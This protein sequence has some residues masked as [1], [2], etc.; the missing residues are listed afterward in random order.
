[1]NLVRFLITK[2]EQLGFSFAP[3]KPV[4][5]PGS[6][7]G[8]YR[9]TDEGDVRYDHPTPAAPTV[10]QHGPEPSSTYQRA[11][12]AHRDVS[13][14][15]ETVRRLYHARLASDEQMVQAVKDLKEAG[16][17]LDEAER[18]EAAS[19]LT[20]HKVK[21]GRPVRLRDP[22]RFAARFNSPEHGGIVG[23]GGAILPRE[24]LEQPGVISDTSKD[25][26]RVMIHWPEAGDGNLGAW[27]DVDML[28]VEPK[29]APAQPPPGRGMCGRCHGQGQIHWADGSKDVCGQ[30]NGSGTVAEKPATA[31]ATAPKPEPQPKPDPPAAPAPASK[32]P[33]VEGSDLYQ[34]AVAAFS[35]T[36]FTPEKRAEAAIREY[37]E[38]LTADYALLSKLAKTDEKKATLA[39]EWPRY[40]AGYHAK[41][42]AWLHSRS[43][44]MS[45][46][47]AGPSN[48]PVRR[49]EKQL[50]RERNR[51]DD[52]TD[53]RQRA[54][55]AIRKKLTPELQPIMAG[56]SDATTRL[57]EE[58]AKLEKTRDTYKAINAAIRKHK[59]A[60]PEA[61]VKAI[62]EVAGFKS[63]DTARKLLEPDFAGRVGIADYQLTNLGANIRRLQ[64]RL[65]SVSEAKATPGETVEGQHATIEDDPPGNR[66]RLTFPGKP[67][68]EVRSRLKHG[69]FRWAPTLGVWQAYRNTNSLA[70]ARE[71]AGVI[72]KA[73][74]LVLRP[75]TRG[76]HYRVT[77]EGA[78]R[79]D[80]P[81][82]YLGIQ[83]GVEDEARIKRWEAAQADEAAEARGQ[84]L[85]RLEGRDREA[86]YAEHLAASGERDPRLQAMDERLAAAGGSAEVHHA[87]ETCRQCGYD[88][89]TK[90]SGSCAFCGA[91]AR[92]RGR[93]V[94]ALLLKGR[95]QQ[96]KRRL[97]ADPKDPDG[98]HELGKTRRGKPVYLSGA[99]AGG[100]N[101]EDHLDAATFHARAHEHH[102]RQAGVHR[103][104]RD[105]DD[106][107]QRA[108]T[109]HEEHERHARLA[110]HHLD[111]VREHLT[112][113]GR[114]GAAMLDATDG[115]PRLGEVVPFTDQDRAEA[116]AALAKR[117]HHDHPGG[118]TDHDRATYG[119]FTEGK[120]ATARD[121]T[122]SAQSR[123]RGPRPR[124]TRRAAG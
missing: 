119:R 41:Y 48:F 60:G 93:I 81:A 99:E 124:P 58:I 121:T 108:E 61:Q 22:A 116:K 72:Q 25:K 15:H 69:G 18:A 55:A 32:P 47:I 77:G 11:L 109:H 104:A 74:R 79:Y 9:I 62:M 26:R 95:V 42:A 114:G 65:T 68:A 94:K 30:C 90:R 46:M 87:Q 17:R 50:A 40:V 1:M 12:D 71:V 34:A 70:L 91:S 16:A 31:P 45:P 10:V 8:H 103:T 28:M 97:F 14:R 73:R 19:T 101:D 37:E 53:Y 67:S 39:A 27:V 112:A 43:G 38:T 36:S 83:R 57:R 35:G 49:H 52:A 54:L 115:A 20:V 75:G 76:G 110:E 92:Q 44:A 84:E 100:Y 107:W 78:V 5:R 3:R 4:Q 33:L 88:R 59:A 13:Q 111:R 6:R 98:Q 51:I 82:D 118:V 117:T 86:A 23:A 7:G 102:D 56:A 80:L 105:G 66:V 106:D 96:K 122:D 2:A 24:L 113:A 63:E 120:H 21:L 85:A 123:R 89:T 64:A 29:A